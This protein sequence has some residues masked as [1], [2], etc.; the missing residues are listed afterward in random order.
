MDIEG[1]LRFAAAFALVIGLITLLSYAA[2]RW[3]GIARVS[4][5]AE[6]R[7]SI[8]EAVGVDAKRRLVIVRADGEDR[9][10]L[11][12]GG[13]GDLDLGPLSKPKAPADA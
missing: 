7:L 1:I 6:R 8:V 12:G 3:R 11:L 5:G 4:G 13:G 10:L 9:L 2:R